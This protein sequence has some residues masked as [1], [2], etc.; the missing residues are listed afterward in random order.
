MVVAGMDPS[1][2]DAVYVAGGPTC[3]VYNVAPTA[4]KLWGR[5]VTMRVGV[6]PVVGSMRY[7]PSL[8]VK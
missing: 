1:R 7:R 6:P 8:C 3:T 2:L 4:P 5:G